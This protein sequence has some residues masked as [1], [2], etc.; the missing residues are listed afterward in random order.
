MRAKITA[1][2]RYKWMNVNTYS[3]ERQL[4]QRRRCKWVPNVLL[5]KRTY[6]TLQKIRANGVSVRNIYILH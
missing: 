4:W 6:I 5:W 3:Q 1:D 2:D